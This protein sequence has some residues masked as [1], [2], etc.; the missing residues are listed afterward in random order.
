M[1]RTAFRR[2]N[3]V[4]LSAAASGLLLLFSPV[5]NAVIA[6]MPGD[7]FVSLE[8]GP[9]Q[10]RLPDGT[11]RS[12]LVPTVPGTGEGMAF[13]SNGNLYVTRWCVDSMCST[14]NTVEMY[15]PIGR[16]WGAVGG[17]YNC[18][19]HALVFQASGTAWVGQ[20]G[21]SGD[22]L[23][24]VPGQPPV[25]FD[26]AP[27]FQGSFWIDLA[28]DGCTMFYTSFGPNVK[29]YDVCLGA[30]LPDFNSAP[31][32]GG[33][34]QDLRVLPDGGVLVSSGSVIAR[35]N[36]AGTLDRTYQGPA[37]STLWS[38]LDLNGDGTFWA[39]NYFSSNVYKF[40]LD[41][42]AIVS[43]FN[44]GTPPNQVVGIRVWK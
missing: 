1:Q 8:S 14:G 3:V 37:E 40:N 38:G 21:C 5:A 28:P 23:K 27:D 10:W 9:V 22:V 20:A 2:W 35:L 19:P 34:A 11:L 7:V 31:V 44:A 30:Q 43:S 16:S 41:T 26:V 39:G 4:T 24:F 25:A 12:V 42:G 36:S 18:N 29:R 13:D 32:P 33:V 6:F 17:P 15:D